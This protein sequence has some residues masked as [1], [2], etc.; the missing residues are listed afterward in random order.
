MQY[1]YYVY[2]LCSIEDTVYGGLVY[3]G[4]ANL[5]I[6]SLTHQ[7]PGIN[8]KISLISIHSKSHAFSEILGRLEENGKLCS[9]MNYMLEGQGCIVSLCMRG[10]W[11]IICVV[12]FYIINISFEKKYCKKK[13]IFAHNNN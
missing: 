3:H 13:Y 10:M 8:L 9:D 7:L 5:R 4:A 11:K 1:R 2:N 12:F 6:N